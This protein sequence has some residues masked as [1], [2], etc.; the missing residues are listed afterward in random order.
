MPISLETAASEGNFQFKNVQRKKI[1]E[2]NE[3]QQKGTQINL[4]FGM[5]TFKHAGRVSRP[6]FEGPPITCPRGLEKEDYK[7][8]ALTVFDRNNE[9]IMKTI[10]TEAH[11]QQKGFVKKTDVELDIGID[12]KKATS[13]SGEPLDIY[14]SPSGDV[15]FTVPADEELLVIGQKSGGWLQVKTKGIK[16]HVSQIYSK[17]AEALYDKKDLIGLE[18]KESATDIEAMIKNGIYFPKNKETNE[19]DNEKNPTEYA[20]FLY[21]KDRETG[22]ENFCSFIMA[23]TG[24]KIHW[25][26]LVEFSFTGIPVYDYGRYLIG[27]DKINP[28]VKIVSFIVTKLEKIERKS[29]QQETLD[30]LRVDDEQTKKNLAILAEARKRN[31]PQSAPTKKSGDGNVHKKDPDEDAEIDALLT[32]IG[33]DDVDELPPSG[34]TNPDEIPGLD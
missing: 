20:S 10:D 33:D 5:L 24:E 12:F 28:Q 6:A 25:K 14:G 1:I 26:D 8:K 31:S 3:S 11:T 13:K 22:E 30:R 19:F 2:Q 17:V 18:S 4:T 9:D 29:I 21:Y 23:G 7:L 16:G 34:D 32:G 27:K 15:K